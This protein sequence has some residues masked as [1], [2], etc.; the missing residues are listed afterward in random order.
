MS[1]QEIKFSYAGI[2]STSFTVKFY[3]IQLNNNPI[4]TPISG[5]KNMV[6]DKLA[7]RD[8]ISRNRTEMEAITFSLIVSPLDEQ[9]TDELRLQIF[10]WLG[11]RKEQ[12]F[13]TSDNEKKCLYG[14]FTNAFNLTLM[15][16]DKGYIELEF[17]AT[18]PYWLVNNTTTIDCTLASPTTP[19]EFT[20]NNITNVQH[21][22][23]EDY[24]Y[25]PKI[26]AD[27]NS[28]ATNFK[29]VNVSNSNRETSFTNL[30]ANEHLYIDNDLEEIETLSGEQ[31]LSKFNDNY[32]KLIKGVNTIRCYYPC[33]LQ[34]ECQF[35][36][37]V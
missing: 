15:P 28:N 13:K 12:E 27:L 18:T 6:F 9:W 4:S 25:F 22:K 16:N 36:Q 1:Y 33:T 24:S 14:I 2:K 20:I 3:Q 21:P 23:Y 19:I 32:F 26:Y 29:L 7:Y 34:I 37:F 30:A 11:S 35:P 5:S 31:V 17:Q 10:E 8:T